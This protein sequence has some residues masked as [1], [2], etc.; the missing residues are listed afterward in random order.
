MTDLTATASARSRMFQLLALGFSHPVEEFYELL[1]DGSYARTLGDITAQ[2]LGCECSLPPQQGTFAEFEAD[3]I[4]LFQMGRGG[5]PIIALTAGDHKEVCKEQ[6]RPEFLLQYTAW[7]RHFGL[8][9]NEDEGANE[10][11]DHLVCQLELMAW[12]S[13]L[14]A[15]AEHEPAQQQGYQRAQQDFLQRHLQGFL[16]QLVTALR[17]AQDSP[18]GSRFHLA[19][20]VLTL[21]ATETLLRQFSAASVGASLTDTSGDS[22]QI[23]A[24]NL[25]G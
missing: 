11:P 2:A 23:A 15:T 18:A 14:E 19:L 6:G 16:E 1:S 17:A 7:Y 9:T 5:K 8:K 13:H 25:W 21:E 22:D 4:H 3:Y 10:L 20:A 24:V 12:L